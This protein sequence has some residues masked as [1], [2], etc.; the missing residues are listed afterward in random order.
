MGSALLGVQIPALVRCSRAAGH[1][2]R[3]TRFSEQGRFRGSVG[4]AVNAACADVHLLWL[5]PAV[6]LADGADSGRRREVP[7]VHLQQGHAAGGLC[8]QRSGG[9]R[10]PTPPLHEGKPLLTFPLLLFPF[11]VAGA[12]HLISVRSEPQAPTVPC[13]HYLKARFLLFHFRVFPF[14]GLVAFYLITVELDPE[15][16]I[17]PRHQHMR[18]RCSPLPPRLLCSPSRTTS[19]TTPLPRRARSATASPAPRSSLHA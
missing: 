9:A 5:P 3:S 6:W 17:V 12:F 14:L 10:H 16:P 15:V 11:L 2:L 18:A 4:A 8:Y 19:V 13:H 7:E 1:T